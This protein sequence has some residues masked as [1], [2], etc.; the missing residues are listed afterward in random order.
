MAKKKIRRKELLKKDDEFISLSNRFFQYVSAH[1]KQVQYLIVSLMIIIA[2]VIGISLYF[3]H[4]NKKALAAYNLAYKNSVSDFSPDIKEDTINRSIEEL[5]KLIK[6]YGW[7]KMATL[8][9]PQLAYLKF[10]QGKYDEAISLYQTYLKKDKSGSIYRSMAHFGIAA[11]YEAKSEYQSAISNLKKIVDDENNFLKEE[12]MFSLGRIYAVSGQ[13]EMSK[14][15]FKDF[16]NQ[17][18]ES[19]LIPLAKANLTK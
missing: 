14:E 19:P 10:G 18:K 8:A 3:K 13:R 11:A 17:F 2:I 1:A 7:T 12:A 15:I 9:I 16:I 4:L 5:D 6:K